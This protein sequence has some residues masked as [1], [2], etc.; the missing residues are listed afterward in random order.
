MAYYSGPS[1][2]VK[3]FAATCESTAG[4]PRWE[5]GNCN[6]R[7][8][9]VWTERYSD[10]VQLASEALYETPPAV[11]IVT[12]APTRATEIRRPAGILP[13][14]RAAKWSGAIVV[15]V[16]IAEPIEEPIEEVVN[17]AKVGK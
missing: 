5:D 17:V 6:G 9:P 1:A 7:R 8:V 4:F 10:V 2:D 3:T 16:P 13:T 12:V 14:T 15:S 11:A